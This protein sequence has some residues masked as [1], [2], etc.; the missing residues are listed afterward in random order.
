MAV[1]PSITWSGPERRR[2]KRAWDGPER[3][4]DFAAPAPMLREM[5]PALAPSAGAVIAAGV[6]AG[7][8][9]AALE[10]TLSAMVLGQ[11]LWA[12]LHMIAAIV[13]GEGVLPAPPAPD[14]GVAAAAVAVHMALSLV[15]AA[16]LG[17]IVLR[18]K[19]VAAWWI[20]LLLGVALYFVNFYGFSAMF[21]WFVQAR[22]TIA[23]VSHAVFGLVLGLV[24][25]AIDKRQS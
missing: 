20:G 13:L 24:Y 11:P 18:A 25:R 6:V 19:P 4:R 23:L 1:N 2:E 12:P 8:V 17:A 5:R 16:L 10:M 21:P 9:F 7:L 14:L 22:G 3:R 15:Y